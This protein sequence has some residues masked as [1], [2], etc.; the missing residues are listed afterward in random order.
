MVLVLRRSEGRGRTWI[1]MLGIFG[2]SLLYGDGIITPAISVLS[3]VEGL[4][5]VTPGLGV[6]V[7]PI[8]VGIL[9]ALFAVAAL[10]YGSEWG[11]TGSGADPHA[12]VV[13]HLPSGRVC[14][15]GVRARRSSRGIHHPFCCAGGWMV[16]ATECSS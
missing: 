2:A 6:W 12:G 10:G 11:A 5:V 15:R 16:R 4:E 3:A 9:V 1:L 14:W 13:R 8:T 7:V